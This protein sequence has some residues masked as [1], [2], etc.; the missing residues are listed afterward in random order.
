MYIDYFKEIDLA[1]SYVLTRFK[2]MHV[3]NANKKKCTLKTI[4]ELIRDVKD[5]FNV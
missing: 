2:T 5:D 3:Y 1:D 4:R